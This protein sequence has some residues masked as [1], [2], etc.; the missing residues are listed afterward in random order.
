MIMVFRYSMSNFLTKRIILPKH[1][2]RQQLPA[3]VI[4]AINALLLLLRPAV[5]VDALTP[6]YAVTPAHGRPCSCS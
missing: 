2:N 1:A 5:T 6:C 3:G 4:A